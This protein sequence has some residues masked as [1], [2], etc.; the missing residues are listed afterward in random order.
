MPSA[1]NISADARLVDAAYWVAFEAERA[2]VLRRRM[3]WCMSILLGILAFSALGTVFELQEYIEGKGTPRDVIVM[4]VLD[5]VALVCLVVATMLYVLAGKPNRRRL[6]WAITIS[7]IAMTAVATYFEIRRAMEYPTSFLG[8]PMV[9][10]DPRPVAWN[11]ALFAYWL[12]ITV[13]LLVIPMRFGES[14]RLIAG[15]CVVYVGVCIW[16]IGGTPGLIAGHA[17]LAILGAIPAAGFS[18]W[19]FL[20]FDAQFQHNELKGR[21]GE[22]SAELSQARTLHE[23]L[24]PAPIDDGPV[25]IRYVYEPMR[26]IGGDFLFVRRV[27]GGPMFV[28]LIDVSGHGVPAALAVNRLHGELV[29]MFG[30]AGR[31]AGGAQSMSAAE[32]ITNLNEYVHLT[33]A[34]QC[35]FATAVCLKIDRGSGGG[36][37]EWA[38]AGHPPALVR[39]GA[40]ALHRLEPTATMLGV[41]EPGV[42]A[43]ESR[44]MPI[45]PGDRIVAYTDG[46]PETRDAEGAELGMKRVEEIVGRA[47]SDIRAALTTAAAAH[48]VGR[49]ADD[50]LVVEVELMGTG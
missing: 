10:P 33:L 25:R 39:S 37:L 31:A 46:L 47:E 44:S 26:E 45:A 23:A 14:I 48:R 19:R 38:N 22:L 24:F 17:A 11:W 20:R 49:L 9:V 1:A 36:S 12:L 41:L 50:M 15:C 18:H 32:V 28:V 43:C 6:V 27:E 2:R 29:R 34:D 35:V 16:T 3:V 7:T 42:F 5:D 4:G 30:A 8:E 21:F 40:G 13:P